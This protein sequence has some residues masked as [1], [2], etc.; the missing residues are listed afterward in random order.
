MV[1]WLNISAADPDGPARHHWA[2][3]YRH[4]VAVITSPSTSSVT[5][6]ADLHAMGQFCS[7]Y[8]AG[9]V[10]SDTVGRGSVYPRRDFWAHHSSCKLCVQSF[11][12]ETD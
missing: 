1:R 8:E 5:L 2:D 7:A 10:S 9:L 4:A 11:K 6:Q 3:T 12:Q